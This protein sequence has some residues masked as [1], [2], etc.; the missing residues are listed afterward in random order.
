MTA[1][2]R[3]SLAM[4][5]V[6][7]LAACDA[8]SIRTSA[9]DLPD[10]EL[11]SRVWPAPPEAAASVRWIAEAAG[12]KPNFEVL[13]GEFTKPVGAFATVQGA[14]RY[15]VYDA[16]RFAWGH[17]RARWRDMGVIAH[18]IGHHFGGHTFLSSADA[19][20]RELEADRF[21]GYAA[22]ML[23]SSLEQ[24]LAWT[25]DLAEAASETHPERARRIEAVSD[26]W[27]LGETFKQQGGLACTAGWIGEP[28]MVGA[29][30]CRPA[31]RCDGEQA[32]IGVACR[33]DESRWNWMD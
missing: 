22:A 14:K 9:P 17:G 11:T 16:S 7:A 26:G 2:V 6:V 33:V 5:A 27:R 25:R 28:V 10:F 3:K 13:A 4:S 1:K 8:S 18:E 12:M 24:A 31:R 19:H 30:E 23:G 20:E 21:A 29:E 32:V 15:V